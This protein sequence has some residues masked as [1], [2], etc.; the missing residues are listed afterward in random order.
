M[1]I[2]AMVLWIINDY[3][4]VIITGGLAAI[5]RWIE[6]TKLKKEFRRKM[7]EGENN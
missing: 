7:G 3:G 2:W 4:Q 6:K 1:K 5:V